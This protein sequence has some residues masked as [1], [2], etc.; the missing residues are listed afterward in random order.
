MMKSNGSMQDAAI[1]R[2]DA[3]IEPNNQKRYQRRTDQRSQHQPPGNKAGEEEARKH[4]E[5]FQNGAA[6]EVRNAVGQHFRG[7]RDLRDV[8][9]GPGL[10]KG[11]TVQVDRLV[12]QL[13]SDLARYG[14]RHS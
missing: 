14:S 11:C 6:K 4:L 9:A 10:R 1:D 12:K 2:L 3:A 13:D 5:R 7:V 8:A